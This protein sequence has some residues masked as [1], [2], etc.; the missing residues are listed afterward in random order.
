MPKL[1]AASFLLIGALVVS[2]KQDTQV[3]QKKNQAATPECAAGAICFSGEVQEGKEFRKDFSPDL[4]FVLS[5]PGEIK[6]FSK[7]VGSQCPNSVWVAN[8]PFR[9][10]HE[11]EIDSS[12]DWTAELEVESSPREFRFAAQCAAYKNLE[13]LSDNDP[14]KYFHQLPSVASGHGRFWITDSK[15]THS[16]G[17]VSKENGA[18]EWIRFSVEIQPP[19]KH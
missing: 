9:A 15:I 2:A 4:T 14:E 11:T 17:A 19:K 8:P 18:V 3:A 6:V 7:E 10:H 1:A 12:Y 13:E 5:L 16:R